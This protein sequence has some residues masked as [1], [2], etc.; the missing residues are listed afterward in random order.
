MQRWRWVTERFSEVTINVDHAIK[1]PDAPT[2]RP[3]H[4]VFVCLNE[5]PNLIT[6]TNTTTALAFVGFRATVV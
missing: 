6:Y 2:G 3:H 5:F 1:A 4:N